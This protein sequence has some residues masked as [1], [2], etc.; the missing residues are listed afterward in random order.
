MTVI[1]TLFFFRKSSSA[2]VVHTRSVRLPRNASQTTSMRNT[3][4]LKLVHTYTH[5]KENTQYMMHNNH[6][7]SHFFNHFLTIL[8]SD[9]LVLEA[10]FSRGAI[11]TV[12]NT[13]CWW[14]ANVVIPDSPCLM[15]SAPV[16][17]STL[18]NVSFVALCALRTAVRM[19]LFTRIHTWVNKSNLDVHYFMT[20]TVILWILIKTFAKNFLS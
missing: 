10:S 19:C 4:Q 9:D 3:T 16:T 12:S 20:I 6:S 13:W 1:E 14:N 8:Y 11:A 18:L 15:D 7:L 2:W 5:D 17:L